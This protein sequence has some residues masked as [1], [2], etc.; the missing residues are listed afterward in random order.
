[1]S[2]LEARHLGRAFGRARARQESSIQHRGR[3]VFVPPSS[4]S[5]CFVGPHGHFKKRRFHVFFVRVCKT[6][7]DTIAATTRFESAA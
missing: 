3:F 6:F 4:R 2:Q 5:S 7:F 1:V